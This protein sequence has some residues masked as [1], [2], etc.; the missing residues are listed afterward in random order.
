VSNQHYY[1]KRTRYTLERCCSVVIGDGIP[2]PIVRNTATS[3]LR[4][5][6]VADNNATCITDQHHPFPIVLNYIVGDR[7]IF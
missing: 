4:N 1:L 2:T 3:V 7:R 6:I 5:D